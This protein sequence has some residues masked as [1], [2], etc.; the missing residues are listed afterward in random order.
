[1]NISGIP[2]DKANS[3]AATAVAVNAMRAAENETGKRIII[4]CKVWAMMDADTSSSWYWGASGA[5]VPADKSKDVA[6]A[7]VNA[8][9]AAKPN[10]AEYEVIVSTD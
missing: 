10:P 6:V 1:V 3:V 4:V 9:V 7:A 8:Y 5:A 2:V